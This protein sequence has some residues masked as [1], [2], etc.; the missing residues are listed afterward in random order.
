MRVSR[1]PKGK[2]GVRPL[3]ELEL[4]VMKVLWHKGEATGKEVWEDIRSSRKTAL[5]TVLTVLDRLSGKGFTRRTRKE[6]LYIYTPSVSR[7]DYTRD[8]SG[9]LLKDYMDLSS[10][11]LIASFMD[12]LD[13]VSSDEVEKLSR[14]IEK[15][16]KERG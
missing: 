16:K 9:R 1:N 10:S 6:G 3:G 5:T 12:A 2:N 8:V 4:E 13:S 7:E 14:L 15:K 11:S